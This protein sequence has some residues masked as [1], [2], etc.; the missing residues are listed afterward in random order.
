M[1]EQSPVQV[2]R[3]GEGAIARVSLCA[4]RGNVLTR[5]V[6]ATL[7]AV[8]RELGSDPHVKAVML[9]SEEPDFSFGASVAEHAPGEVET[10]LPSFCKLF[11][12]IASTGLPVGAA[13]RGRCLGGGLELCLAAHHV[14]VSEDAQLGL[15]EV[16]LGVFPPVAAAVLPLRVRQPVADLLI[17]QGLSVRGEEAVRLGLADAVAPSNK[18][19]ERVVEW[20]SKYTKLSACAVRFA[21]RASRFAWDEALGARL[22]RLEEI[23]LR[24]LMATADAQ[25]G[26]RAFMEKRQP[27]W[28]DR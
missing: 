8:F 26:I 14:V 1:Q 20:A 5:A 4:G 6:I 25:E 12:T 2:S 16:T 27:R 3:V 28:V 15:P 17:T 22:D 18:V 7:E 24:E 9:T 10:M 11:R 23:Y 13:V 21:T 19:E